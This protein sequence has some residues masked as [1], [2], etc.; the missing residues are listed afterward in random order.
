MIFVMYAIFLLGYIVF[1]SI[2]LLIELIIV[3][4]IIT[5]LQKFKLF[6]KFNFLKIYLGNISPKSLFY[7]IVGIIVNAGILHFYIIPH[8]LPTLSNSEFGKVCDTV[9]N[10]S[11]PESGCQELMPYRGY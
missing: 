3:V 8:V 6:K 11:A 10:P 7:F 5:F 2:L 9:N 4:Q 1:G